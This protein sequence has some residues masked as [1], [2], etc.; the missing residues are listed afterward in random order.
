MG[1]AAVPLFLL[2]LAYLLVEGVTRYKTKHRFD[3]LYIYDQFL[4]TNRAVE[5]CGNP[6]NQIRLL[7][8]LLR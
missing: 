5:K 7:L 6:E 8:G 1:E 3:P 4:E 2:L